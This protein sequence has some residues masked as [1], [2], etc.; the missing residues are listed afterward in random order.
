MVSLGPSEADA[1]FL[2]GQLCVLQ[3]VFLRVLFYKNIAFRD[4]L[5]VAIHGG[6]QANFLVDNTKYCYEFDS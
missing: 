2:I 4:W 5:V 3:E 1:V 6:V